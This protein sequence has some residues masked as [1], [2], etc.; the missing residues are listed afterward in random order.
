MSIPNIHEEMQCYYYD[1]EHSIDMC[2][3]F[4]KDKEKYNLSRTKITE[5]VPQ[6]D[7]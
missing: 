4:K 3:K 2:E 6:M 7:T 5:E 1:G